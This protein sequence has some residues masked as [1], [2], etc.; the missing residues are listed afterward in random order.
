[1]SNDIKQPE[2]TLNSRLE[3][4]FTT[5]QLT[6]PQQNKTLS[7][8]EYHQ[9]LVQK[10]QNFLR[11]H[12]RNKNDIEWFL[13]L[14]DTIF[15][16]KH[17]IEGDGSLELPPCVINPKELKKVSELVHYTITDSLHFSILEEI[18]LMEKWIICNGGNLKKTSQTFNKVYVS[19]RLVESLSAS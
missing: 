19:L 3:S 10:A 18:E 7:L 14:H 13:F 6:I 15:S 11:R 9:E 5:I 12:K 16:S 8:E 4:V 2:S 1:M 17:E